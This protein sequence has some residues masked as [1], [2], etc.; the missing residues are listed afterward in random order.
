MSDPASLPP[1]SAE[2]LFDDFERRREA[3]EAVD[4][5]GLCRTHPDLRQ[6]YAPSLLRDGGPRASSPTRSQTAAGASQHLTANETANHCFRCAQLVGGWG[7]PA[8][9]ALTLPRAGR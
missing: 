1:A 4:F 5:D 7:E 2:A 3:G 8:R 9:A 6:P